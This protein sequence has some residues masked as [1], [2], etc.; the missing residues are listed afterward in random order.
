MA[1]ALTHVVG[2]TPSLL[3]WAAMFSE[4]VRGLSVALLT[5]AVP[6]ILI[7]AACTDDGD[8]APTVPAGTPTASAGTPTPG[9]GD[10]SP[11]APAGTPTPA[12]GEQTPIASPNPIAEIVAAYV[13]GTGLGGQ[14]F[15]LAQPVNCKAIVEEVD[16]EAAAGKICIH[17]ANSRFG[18]T[19]GVAEVLV[20]GTEVAWELTFERQDGAWVV[21]GA[22]E[23]TPE[24]D[25]Q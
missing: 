24:A 16:K 9:N 21:T 25:E 5:L 23:T 1:R 10:E 11:T 22:Q 19:S 20:Y 15:E 3:E 17:F 7:A 18:E 14:T 13:A 6:V 4:R 8:E 2:R 12:A